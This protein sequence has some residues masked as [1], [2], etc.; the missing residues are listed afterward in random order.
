MLRWE[1][2]RGGKHFQ[3]VAKVRTQIVRGVIISRAG[4][5]R[6]FLTFFNSKQ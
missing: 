5:F 3:Y 2:G 1:V 4:H 6:Y